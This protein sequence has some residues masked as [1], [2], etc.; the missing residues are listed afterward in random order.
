MLWTAS[1]GNTRL[2]A[3]C[4]SPKNR[5]CAIQLKPENQALASKI[6]ESLSKGDRDIIC[7]FY[8]EGQSAEDIE[9]DLG[10]PAGYVRGL[11]ASVKAKFF[12]GLGPGANS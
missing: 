1:S 11:K 8:V 7:R 12:E 6:L 10:I 4:M 9:R 3:E 2:Q 5:R